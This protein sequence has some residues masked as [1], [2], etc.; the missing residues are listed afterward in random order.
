[1]DTARSLAVCKLFFETF[2]VAGD[3]RV[4]GGMDAVGQGNIKYTYKIMFM[5]REPFFGAI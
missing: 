4:I 5:R 3:E 2:F 1:M